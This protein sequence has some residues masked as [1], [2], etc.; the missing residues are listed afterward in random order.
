MV[1]THLPVPEGKI[2]IQQRYEVAPRCGNERK[3]VKELQNFGILK[4]NEQTIEMKFK[5]DDDV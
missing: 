4:Q 3:L 1:D 2:G 5:D